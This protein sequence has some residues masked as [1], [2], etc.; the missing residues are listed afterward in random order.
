MVVSTGLALY[1]VIFFDAGAVGRMIGPTLSLIFLAV[2]VV[3]IFKRKGIYK[4]SFKVNLSEI[5]KALKFCTPLII[6]NY[7]YFPV[8]NLDRLL[9]ERL[10]NTKE[11]G[12]YN[13]GL[14]IAGYVGTFFVT[15]YMA[16]E[17]DFY[18]LTSER[19]SHEYVRLALLYIIILAIVALFAILFSSSVVA[20]LTSNR[21]LEATKYVNIMIIS[22][23]F[24][25]IGDMFQQLYNSLNSTNL[26]L[27]RNALM[28][29]FGIVVYSVL[30]TRMEFIGAA[31]ARVVLFILYFMIGLAIF[32]FK[33]RKK[34]HKYLRL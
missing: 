34:I 11:F 19:K 12:Y 5:R 23:Y 31:W 32:G 25:S 16:F 20:Y 17:P 2:L 8:S 13:I 6:G 21:Y 30:I 7:L 9:L 4:T 10:D 28:A 15:L 22:L 24:Y 1:F 14:T 18:K 33:F 27:L 26:S 3:F 29:V